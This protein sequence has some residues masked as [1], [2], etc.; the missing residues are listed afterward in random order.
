MKH[1]RHEK[2]LDAVGLS[3]FRLGA[4]GR[5]GADSIGPLRVL[6]WI[7]LPEWKAKER[8]VVVL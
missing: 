3:I 2:I 5:K 1:T 4:G 8:D 6:F 7:T